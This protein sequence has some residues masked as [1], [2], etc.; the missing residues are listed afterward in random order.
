MD[1]SAFCIIRRD[2]VLLG[3]EQKERLHKIHPCDGL[4]GACADGL[5]AAWVSPDLAAG[6]DLRAATACF[7]SEFFLRAR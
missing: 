7:S 2:F 3:Y 6:Q 4:L 1:F 5:A